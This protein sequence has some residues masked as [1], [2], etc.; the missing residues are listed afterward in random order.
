MTPINPVRD[1]RIVRTRPLVS[2][3]RLRRDAPLTEGAEDVV[4]A[5]RHDVTRILDGHDDRLLVVVGP[6]S[7]HD[8]GAALDYARRLASALTFEADFARM[9]AYAGGTEA[10]QAISQAS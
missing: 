2:P 9:D 8:P 5:S 6:C 10:M 1:R 3:E 4:V 7:V